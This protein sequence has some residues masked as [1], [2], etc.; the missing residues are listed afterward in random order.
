MTIITERLLKLEN[1]P[2]KYGSHSPDSEM[3][4]ME[5]VAW[6]AGEPWSDAPK[7]ACPVISTFLRSWNDAL[8]NDAERDRLLKPFIPN[9]ID[10]K[11]TKEL[12]ERRSLMCADWLVRVN[13]PA[14]LRLAGSAA[15]ADALSALPE[16]TSMAQIPSLRGSL[17]VVRH[18]AA[19]AWDA[20]RDA[21]RD[22]LK[23]TINFLQQSAL[24]LVNRMIE[25][26]PCL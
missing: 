16:I 17:E 13:T 3:C 6:V 12:E 4:V 23:P 15:H 9:L 14:W 26:K 20:A 7:C 11:G 25:A 1:L 18:D 2:L 10:T 19:A 24:A 5:A 22:A 21:A 8:P